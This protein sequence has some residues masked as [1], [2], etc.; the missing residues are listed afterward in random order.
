MALSAKAP[1]PNA[2]KLFI[3]YLCSSEGQKIVA[4]TGEFVLHPGIYPSIK[5]ADKIMASMTY[6]E[7][8]SAEQLAKLQSE[9]RQ[10][11]VAK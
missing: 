7:N 10:I 2:A 8:P 3:E 5:S 6:M 1:N 9:F 11:F 4:D